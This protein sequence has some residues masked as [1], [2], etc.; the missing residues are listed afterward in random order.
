GAPETAHWSMPDPA[1]VTKSNQD[2]YPVFVRTA[3][4]I[5]TR[6]DVLIAELVHR[7]DLERSPHGRR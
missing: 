3:D 1:A 4:E 5:E 7:A 2:S 6:V